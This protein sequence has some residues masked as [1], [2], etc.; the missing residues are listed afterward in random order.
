MRCYTNFY[1]WNPSTG[2]SKRIPVSPITIATGYNTNN[3]FKVLYGF[4]Y[5]QSS[6]DYIVVVG[7]YKSGYAQ[8]EVSNS[9]KLEIF[10]LRANK[11]I[12]L[13]LG[14]H[15]RT[16]YV[17]PKVGSFLNGSIHWLVY[18]YQTKMNVIIAFDTKDMTMSEIALP[19]DFSSDISHR[20]YD[21]LVFRGLIGV[22]TR[23]MSKIK[24]WVMQEYTVHSS[25]TKTLDFLF[26]PNPNFSPV[27][28][29]NGGDIIGPIANAR[30]VKLNDKGL[31]LEY[32]SYGDCCFF[33]SQLAV[34]TESLLSLPDD[35]EQA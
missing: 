4:G 18:N 22:W 6:D 13:E 11:W 1:L 23:E 8:H 17:D 16:Y 31:L 34:Y 24:I 20:T 5:N 28:F 26:H 15:L 10:S 14:S 33:R 12:Q 27:C 3:T 9:I 2:V 29:T 25:W 7:S 21:L 35:I 32:H 19:D 30:L